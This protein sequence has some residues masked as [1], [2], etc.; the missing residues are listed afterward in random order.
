MNNRERRPR[1]VP[2]IHC[3][4]V[5]V[6]VMVLSACGGGSESDAPGPSSAP[7]DTGA[8][9]AAEPAPAAVEPVTVQAAAQPRRRA[10]AYE[11]KGVTAMVQAR[12]GG[13][14]GVASADGRVRLLD[15]AG[16][17]ELRTLKS[18]G[19][20]ATAGLIFSADGR[21]LVTVGRDSVAQIWDV[22]SGQRRYTLN[23]HEHALR[24]VAASPDGSLIA[25]AGEETSVLLWDGNTGR[26]Q[27]ALRGHTDFVNALAISPDARLLASGD[28]DARILVWDLASGKL[29][30][31]LKGHAGEV[32]AVAFAA[33]GK[34]L[35]SGGEDGKVILWDVVA[36]RQVQAL[37]S[38]RAAVRSVS[39]NTDGALLAAGGQDG[40]V[41]VWDMTS[42]T[43]VQELA[44]SGAAVNALVFDRN[45][46]TQL[47]LGSEESRVRAMSVAR[48]AAR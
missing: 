23:G 16:T 4:A 48:T 38:A 18:E 43:A 5:L 19:S 6:S 21:Y 28:A 14:L 12:D 39:F 1:W 2:W 44:G 34:L 27:R 29:V 13:M 7:K 8:I 40:K 30:H 15:A 25:T 20:A 37:G 11:R 33:D 36:G 22:Q 3:R 9:G 35:A 47:Y 17:R 24:A 45:N 31:T 26:M 42:R 10:L 41:L 46:K 32:N